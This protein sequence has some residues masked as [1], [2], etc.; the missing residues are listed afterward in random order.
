M[1]II[2]PKDIGLAKEERV[3]FD[4]PPGKKWTEESEE[5]AVEK[6]VEYL[7]KKYPRWEFRMVRVGVGKYNFVFA[8]TREAE[9]VS[10]LHV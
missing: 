6:V 2:P 1:R 7:D 10:N 3:N 8:G 4:A 5:Q 9:D